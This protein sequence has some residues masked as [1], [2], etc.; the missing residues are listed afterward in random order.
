M[1]RLLC[2]GGLVC[3]LIG[4][5]AQLACAQERTFGGYACTEDCSGHKAGYDWA[6]GRNITEET[7]CSGNSQSFIEG[8]E[9]YVE[10]PSRGSDADD[11]GQPID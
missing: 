1:G 10:D 11:D 6:E 2:R 9:A 3:T 4:S 8:C 7:E 5:V